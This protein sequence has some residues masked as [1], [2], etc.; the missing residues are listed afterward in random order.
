MN[1]EICNA[2]HNHLMDRVIAITCRIGDI[3]NCFEFFVIQSNLTLH[4]SVAEGER[5][6][7][8][9]KFEDFRTKAREHLI[10][11]CCDIIVHQMQVQG[12]GA[13][14][15]MDKTCGERNL[16][17]PEKDVFDIE[18]VFG[19]AFEFGGELDE[20]GIASACDTVSGE[21]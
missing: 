2:V 5:P 14:S 21:V 10:N 19:G 17:V 12:V 3:A 6:G 13:E 1:K 11:F 18:H 16:Q 7:S 8:E 9:I 20:Y 15:E 4:H